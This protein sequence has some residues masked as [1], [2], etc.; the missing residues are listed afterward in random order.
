MNNRRVT[1]ALSTWGT[2]P[3]L[4]AI[5]RLQVD[6][7][8]KLRALHN[9]FSTYKDAWLMAYMTWS[10]G[11]RKT[12]RARHPIRWL[13]LRWDRKWNE[14]GGTI[15]HPQ[16]GICRFTM[17]KVWKNIL[18]SFIVWSSSIRAC[19]R[20]TK[21]KEHL[22]KRSFIWVWKI[23]IPIFFTSHKKLTAL[24]GVCI[25]HGL[26]LLHSIRISTS[27]TCTPWEKAQCLGWC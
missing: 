26:C 4:P 7:L 6:V 2:P 11:R 8:L 24:T 9:S 10:D 3:V 21:M 17:I 20:G 1:G 27:T 18:F 25:M 5:H 23:F 12:S 13:G 19:T 16:T 22:W 14:D 15:R